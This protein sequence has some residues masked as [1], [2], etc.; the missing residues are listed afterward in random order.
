MEGG[1]QGFKCHQTHPG[2]ISLSSSIDN[3]PSAF[4]LVRGQQ[5]EMEP[6]LLN[7]PDTEVEN[8][9]SSGLYGPLSFIPKRNGKVHLFMDLRG[10]DTAEKFHAETPRVLHCAM[11]VDLSDG[12]LHTPMHQASR[13]HYR[14][15]PVQGLPL[16]S[17][18]QRE[19]VVDAMMVHVRSWGATFTT[20]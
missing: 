12:Y 7:K 11:S 15:I 10:L 8:A 14:D 2:G 4:S 20:I 5:Q 9:N 6:S 1:R 17:V 13:F 18:T 3:L 19:G 16:W